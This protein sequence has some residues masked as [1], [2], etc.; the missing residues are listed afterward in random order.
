M[1]MFFKVWMAQD[2][3]QTDAYKF[4]KSLAQVISA[5]SRLPDP[6]TVHV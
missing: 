2:D 4:Y 3:W 1:A 6:R 5:A